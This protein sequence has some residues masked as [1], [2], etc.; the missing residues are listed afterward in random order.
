M[1][2][3]K[4]AGQSA[5]GSDVKMAGGWAGGLVVWREIDSVSNSVALWVGGSVDWKAASWAD[6]KV[7]RWVGQSAG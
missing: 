4:M 1:T 3:E 5:V 6:P 7:E 2:A